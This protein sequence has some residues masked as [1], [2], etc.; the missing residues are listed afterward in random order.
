M[1]GRQESFDPKTWAGVHPAGSQMIYAGLSGD[2]TAVVR[3]GRAY[4]SGVRC[5]FPGSDEWITVHPDDLK[6]VTR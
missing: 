6:E 5:Q 4:R 2:G 3:V 1:S